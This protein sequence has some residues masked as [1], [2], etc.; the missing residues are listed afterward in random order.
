MFRNI[1]FHHLLFYSIPFEGSPT[2]QSKL[3]Q[4]IANKLM[5]NHVPYF[6]DKKTFF[7]LTT[8]R[9]QTSFFQLLFVEF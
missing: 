5:M 7:F 9:A 2:Q 1:P 4:K 8:V 6:L 3:F